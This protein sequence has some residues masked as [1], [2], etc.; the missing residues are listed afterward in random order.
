M[1]KW[2]KDRQLGNIVNRKTIYQHISMGPK[3]AYRGIIDGGIHD[4]SRGRMI[5]NLK[6]TSDGYYLV[7]LEEEFD[8]NTFHRIT[9]WED[10]NT[11]TKQ[12][13]KSTI[14]LKPGIWHDQESVFYYTME[15][16]GSD[17]ILGGVRER[18]DKWMRQ[19]FLCTTS[20]TTGE[21]KELIRNV[22]IEIPEHFK[23]TGFF[24]FYKHMKSIDGTVSS[25]NFLS[26]AVFIGLSGNNEIF[27]TDVRENE[28]QIN[29]HS[30]YEYCTK[31]GEG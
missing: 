13:V 25:L 28:K 19:G 11:H 4:E 16:H 31:H 14:N 20:L 9:I 1:L 22:F 27:Y 12:R 10:P 2:L 29:Y 8:N 15:C 6:W 18:D 26:E 30:I 7:S 3:F 21:L 23:N 24:C 5:M 17:V